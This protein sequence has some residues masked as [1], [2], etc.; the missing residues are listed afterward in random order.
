MTISHTGIKVPVADIKKVLDWYDAALAPLTYKKVMT[1]AEGMANGYAEEATPYAADWWVNAAG[2]GQTP[3]ASHHAFGVKDRAT[4]DAFYK[5]AIAAGGTDNGAP[6][7]RADYTPDYYAAFVLDP[8]GN[9]IEVVCM[10][11]Q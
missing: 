11:P 7:V 9:N 8:A 3:V 1:F 10:T 4:V 6:G 5:A 2:E